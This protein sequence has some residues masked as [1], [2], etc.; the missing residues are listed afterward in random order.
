ME[1]M[2]A[3]VSLIDFA[4]Q[5]RMDLRTLRRELARGQ[6]PYRVEQGKCS[7]WDQL[8][9]YALNTTKDLDFKACRDFPHYLSLFPGV[10]PKQESSTHASQLIE[11]LTR[12]HREIAELKT[13]LAFYEDKARK[14]PMTAQA[15]YIRAFLEPEL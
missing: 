11:S 4:E 8:G 1:T 7:I 6:I 15:S 12:A 14:E 9:P 2:G 10:K 3:W 13:L 5:N